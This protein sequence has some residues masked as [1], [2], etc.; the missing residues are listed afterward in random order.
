MLARGARYGAGW[1]IGA[2]HLVPGA[3][4]NAALVL[5]LGLAGVAVLRRWLEHRYLPQT[6]LQAGMRSS[7]ATLLGYAGQ[8]TVLALALSTLGLGVERIAWIASALSVGIGFGLQAIVQNFISGLILLAE[9]PVKVGDWVVL[10]QTEGDIRRINV[11]A[12][13]IQLADRSTVIVPNS[14]FVTKSVQNMTLTRA[15]GR[16]LLNLPMP[17]SSDADQVRRLLLDTLRG[18]AQ[19]QQ[20]PAPLVLLSGIEHGQL[21]FQAIAFVADPRQAAVVRSELWF[22]LL[23]ALGAA[24]LPL[25]LPTLA[26]VRDGEDAMRAADASTGSRP[27]KALPVPA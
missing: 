25:A 3:L 2:Y 20:E 13:E 18:H 16:V 11:R 9:R 12:T 6:Q 7:I 21:M 5:A 10:G 22:A 24:G 8:I 4:L 14:E 17:L 1:Q 27:A 23:Q 15:G 26:I 19:V